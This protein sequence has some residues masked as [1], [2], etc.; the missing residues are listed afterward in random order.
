MKD[1]T[2]IIDALSRSAP[3]LE[4]FLSSIPEDAL[5]R[6][7]G[8][9]FWTIAEHA[10]HL[11][12]VQPMLADRIRRFLDEDAPAFV[13]FVPADNEAEAAPPALD[14][15]VAAAAFAAGRA[16]QVALLKEAAPPDWAKHGTHPE[17]T[18][19]SLYIL[20]RHILMHDHW[21]MYRMEELWLTRDEYLTIL[22]G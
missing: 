14:M 4:G 7:R 17:Y 20:A 22:S 16:A 12:D 11:A 5:H 3:I 19:Y 6:R 15:P 18:Q 13:P 8:E 10:N 21:H 1:L 9:G 2:H